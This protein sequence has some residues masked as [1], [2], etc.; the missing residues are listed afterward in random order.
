MARDGSGNYS[1]PEAPYQDGQVIDDDSVNT[2]LADIAVALTGSMTRDGQGVPTANIPMGSRILTGLGAGSAAGHSVRYEQIG[3]LARP[4]IAYVEDA[5]YGAVGDGVTNDAVALQAALDSGN[6]LVILKPGSTYLTNSTLIIPSGVTLDGQSFLPGNPALGTQ[7]IGGAAVS[8]VIQMGVGTVNG[9]EMLKNI[10]I[11]RVSGTPNSARIGIRVFDGYNV[12]CENVHSDNHG[13][14]WQFSAHPTTGSGLGINLHNCHGA[15]AVDT[16]IDVES[17]PELYW[18][19]GRFGMNGSG[20]YNGTSFIRYRGGVTGTAGGPNSVKFTSCQFNQGSNTPNYFMEFVSLAAAYPGVAATIFNFAQ[21]HIEGIDTAAIF[22]DSSWNIIDNITFSQCFFNN[23]SIPF[24]SLNAGS[25]VYNWDFL[26][27]EIACSTFNIASTAQIDGFRIIG[28]WIQ[29]TMA[30][31]PGGTG[32]TVVMLGTNHSGNAVFT[33]TYGKLTILGNN[34]FAGALDISAAL[35]VVVTQTEGVWS[36]LV[37][38]NGST[39]GITQSAA[40]GYYQ[41]VGRMMTISFNIILT[42]KGAG[43]GNVTIIG[44]PLA[45]MAAGSVG[46]GA[47]THFLNCV[48][49][50][51]TV[52]ANTNSS[53]AL[54]LYDSSA[55]DVTP[56]TDANISNTTVFRGTISYFVR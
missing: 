41:L 46:G 35:G 24:F 55:T 49:L 11:G 29:G 25:Q 47:L 21:C 13:I 43:T 17:W 20:D 45:D 16:Y 6:K 27:N 39:T 37:A 34:H 32:S 18:H 42:S 3:A 9:T 33:G 52:I 22:S 5:T 1:L 30:I 50:T 54:N 31:G 51:G 12:Q 19:G 23:P 56:I 40:T 48:G 28:G 53:S 2:N 4:G 38:I 7:I 26:G 10:T 44:Q 8:P 15:R 36:P 14:C